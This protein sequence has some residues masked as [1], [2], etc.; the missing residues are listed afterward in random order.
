[1]KTHILVFAL[2]IVA[3]TAFAQTSL[4]DL[5]PF[6]GTFKCTG[7]AFAS[8]MGPEHA[9]RATVTGK[10]TLGGKWLQVR[11]TEVKT[12]KNPHPFDVIAYWGYDEGTKKLVATSMDNMGG[13]ALE[14]ST[15]WTGDQLVFSGTGHMGTMTMQGRDNF[16]RKG[17]NQITHSFEVQDNAGGWKKLDEETCKK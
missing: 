14:D 6:V 5:D 1:L 15:G 7:M 8:D 13:Y 12:A 16:G 10:W 11:Y 17:K 9:T 3:S 2:L 4:K